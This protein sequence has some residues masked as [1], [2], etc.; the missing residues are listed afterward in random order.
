MTPSND[1]ELTMRTITQT[2]L[3]GP[4]VL[5][6]TVVPRPTPAPTEIQVKVHAVGVNPTDWKARETGGLF[7]QPPFTL[8]ADVS[9]VVEAVGMGVRLFKPGDEVFG[10]PNFP[11]PAN[12]YAEF[13]VAPARH[14]ALKPDVLS[15]VEAAALP[16]VGLTAWQALVE[17]AQLQSGQRVM[18]HAAAGGLG[19][20]AV[21][22]AKAHGA[23]VIGTASKAKHNYLLSLGVDDV[24]DYASDD[25]SVLSPVDIVLDP[26]GGETGTRS[27]PILRRGGHLVSLAGPWEDD[28]IPL[29]ATHGV[30]AGFLLVAADYAGMQEIADLV[31]SG[32]LR[33]RIGL[34]LPMSHVADAHQ[35]GERGDIFGKIILTVVD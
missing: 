25:F 26:I 13:V 11:R 1:E 18:I 16:L 7:G 22:I 10:M 34:V 19:H 20:V 3:G 17:T 24:L 33:P 4:E 21:Q 29:A 15:H 23:Y 12:A 9:G 31:M 28:L 27:I 2:S 8:G 14:F 35:M 6:Q 30:H 5:Q 32:R